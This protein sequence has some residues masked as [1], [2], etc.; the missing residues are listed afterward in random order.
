MGNRGRKAKTTTTKEQM[1]IQITEDQII[2]DLMSKTEYKGLPR[3]VKG[4]VKELGIS[5]FEDRDLSSEVSGYL[6][7]AGD[8]WVIGV[9]PMHSKK[10]QRFTIA[11]EL[12][13][14][15]MHTKNGQEE[16]PFEDTILFRNE[17]YFEPK[18]HQANAFAAKILM[19]EDKIRELVQSGERSVER[20]ADYFKVSVTAMKFQLHTMGYEIR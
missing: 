17:V 3:D 13:H 1:K 10:R 18:E 6:R 16:L 14:F 8:K 9:N 20:L 2:N 4:I 11:H 19:P 15:L 12:G 5:I 7:K